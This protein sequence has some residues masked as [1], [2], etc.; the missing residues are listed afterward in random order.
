MSKSATKMTNTQCLN[1]VLIL[2]LTR[3]EEWKGPFA[4]CRNPPA[5]TNN[6][7]CDAWKCDIMPQIKV[8]PSKATSFFFTLLPLPACTQAHKPSGRRLFKQHVAI[9]PPLL[10]QPPSLSPS[11]NHRL[12]RRRWGGIAPS[13]VA[14][15]LVT[16]S[17]L[18]TIS[19]RA[20]PSPWPTD[21][22]S[23]SAL[24]WNYLFPPF[25]TCVLS[26]V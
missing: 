23:P 18:C 17:A 2:S 10:R 11:G 22:G 25:V 4:F 13:A 6:Y 20:L 15:L 24:V 3:R 14:S 21:T 19:H 8:N 7:R 5:H 12:D 9:T 1:S 26:G 16:N